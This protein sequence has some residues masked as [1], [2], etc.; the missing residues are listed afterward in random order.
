M[1][2]NKPIRRSKRTGANSVLT[3]MIVFWSLPV[4]V[5]GC[6][7]NVTFLTDKVHWLRFIDDCPKPLLGLITGILPSVALGLLMSLVPPFIRMAGK[8]SGSMTVQATDLYCQAWYYAF[9]VVQVFLVT[10]CTSSASAT[11]DA[12]IKDPESAMLLLANNLPKASNFYIAYFLLQ[13]LSVSSGTL[14]QLVTLILSKVLGR[15]LD[16]TPRQKWNRYCMLGKPTMG[17]AYPVMEVLV[18]IALCYA[19]IA[20]LVLIFSF[21]GLALLYLANVYNLSYVQGFTLNA[22]GRNYP[23]ALFQLFCGLYL[24]QVCLIGL[25]IMGKAWGPLVLEIVALVAT[26]LAH[27]WSQRRFIPL[28]SAVPLSV[29]QYIQ[30]M[31]GAQYPSGDQGLREIKNAAVTGLCDED[32]ASS[33]GYRRH[34]QMRDLS[35]DSGDLDGDWKTGDND[36]AKDDNKIGLFADNTS[37]TDATALPDQMPGGESPSSKQSDIFADNRQIPASTLSLSEPVTHELWGPERGILWRQRVATFFQPSKYYTFE[38]VRTRLPRVFEMRMQYSDYELDHPFTDPSVVEKDPIIW[39][40]EDPMGISKKQINLARKMGTDV[41]D[42]NTCY[43]G[44]GKAQYTGD[45]PDYDR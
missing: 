24:S 1:N 34:F 31:E 26:I 23:R 5:V 41:T 25:F 20:P 11:V 3:A 28:F 42:A 8:K 30:G 38:E 22:K 17:V 27:L 16:S 13:G 39:I 43:N 32:T 14:L 9:Q 21:A 7:S 15:V 10:T 12:I 35:R 33:V 2:L 18:C 45:P 6:I 37:A 40:A 36:R 44:K 29:F 19:V 4:A